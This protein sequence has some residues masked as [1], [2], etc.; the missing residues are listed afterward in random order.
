M[1]DDDSSRK[2][3]NIRIGQFKNKFIN[4]T[5]ICKGTFLNSQ[6]NSI[7]N[8]WYFNTLRKMS[9]NKMKNYESFKKQM[10]LII[11]QYKWLTIYRLSCW[12]IVF[13]GWC[14]WNLIRF[15]IFSQKAIWIELKMVTIHGIHL[16]SLKIM[17]F[18]CK[19]WLGNRFIANLIRL[20]SLVWVF[21]PWIYNLKGII[22]KKRTWCHLVDSFCVYIKNVCQ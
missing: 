14:M 3:F 17:T 9:N 18:K 1:F 12:I 10:I 20:D 6:I 7:E 13:E 8:Q 2:Q 21:K 5:F 16:V 22:Q 4:S 15:E 11:I 19:N